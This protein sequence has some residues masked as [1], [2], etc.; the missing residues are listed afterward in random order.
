M[1]IGQSGSPSTIA[2]A[3]SSMAATRSSACA[4]AS[5]DCLLAQAV[6]RVEVGG[7]PIGL[8]GVVGEAE[9]ERETRILHP[10]R[11]VDARPDRE[12]DIGAARR[13]CG[14]RRLA[15]RAQPG[16]VGDPRQPVADDDPVLAA[17]RHHVGDRAQRGEPERRLSAAGGHEPRELERLDELEGDAGPGEPVERI[18]RTG[19]LRVDE[20]VSGRELRRRAAGGER[21]VVVGDDE[22]HARR[23]GRARHRHCSCRSRR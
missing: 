3:S 10:T 9:L 8:L 19:E 23:G 1:P 18:G 11:C 16:K 6:L 15:E 12:R 21:E 14:P 22:A 5:G 17:Q 13:R 2:G 4:S 7:E 20:R